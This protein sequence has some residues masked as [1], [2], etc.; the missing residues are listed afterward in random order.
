MY[1]YVN[2]RP[3]TMRLLFD[4]ERLMAV[5][6]VV[7]SEARGSGGGCRRSEKI[8]THWFNRQAHWSATLDSPFPWRK[9]TNVVFR[10]VAI[11]NTWSILVAATNNGRLKWVCLAEEGLGKGKD[12]WL[13]WPSSITSTLRSCISFFFHMSNMMMGARFTRLDD[14]TNNLSIIF[15]FSNL[16]FVIVFFVK[17]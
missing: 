14:A 5:G 4:V 10:R 9:T 12:A 7:R 17:V 16:R 6:M 11:Q 1:E 3:V 8:C 2:H 13:G 15:A